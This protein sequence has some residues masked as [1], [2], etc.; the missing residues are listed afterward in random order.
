MSGEDRIDI[1]HPHTSLFT[2]NI[3]KQTRIGKE[4]NFQIGKAY[5]ACYIPLCPRGPCVI[6]TCAL[7][8]HY[9]F[10]LL[11]DSCSEPTTEMPSFYFTLCG[12]ACFFLGW[13][14]CLKIGNLPHGNG[15]PIGI[16]HMKSRI[17]RIARCCQ[18]WRFS[19]SF[20][21]L[22]LP[23]FLSSCPFFFGLLVL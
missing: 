19:F 14:N 10:R 17:D 4:S 18:R 1:Q 6:T 23:L 15:G 20:F 13:D 2:K 22:D 9:M 3:G 11:N 12:R 8:L 21:P 5:I 7:S 16:G